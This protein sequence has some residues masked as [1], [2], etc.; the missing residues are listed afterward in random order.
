MLTITFVDHAGQARNISAQTG[1]SLME[2]ARANDIPG[3]DA[4]C[5]G[6]CAC[7]TCHVYVDPAF[8]G[9]VGAPG[10]GEAP[11]LDFIDGAKANSR[12]ACQIELT[13]E[14][15]GLVVRTPESQQ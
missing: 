10:D 9:L 7:A 1:Y 2:A 6:M 3:I 5:G 13:D 11:L 4:D 8:M 15:D 14:L 12:L